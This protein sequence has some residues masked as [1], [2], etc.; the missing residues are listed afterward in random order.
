VLNNAVMQAAGEL[1]VE[2][3]VRFH[4]FHQA[5][6]LWP[7]ALFFAVILIMSLTAII[8]VVSTGKVDRLVNPGI[9]W[10]IPF[11]WAALFI[12]SPYWNARRQRK[13]QQYLREPI[14]Y[15]F[16]PDRLQLE[17]PHYS[18]EIT[19][20]LVLRV[21]ETKTTFLIYY[22]PNTAWILPKRFFWNDE[23]AV[24]RWREFARENLTRYKRAFHA[25]GML[26]TWI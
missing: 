1:T 10:A 6:R 14:R 3:I 23:R 13:L 5:R 12:A 4:Y 16:T 19:W 8:A 22:E 11:L 9:Y 26:S 15:H 7:V 25:P 20:S 24:Q 21:Y 18:T 2:D 17:G